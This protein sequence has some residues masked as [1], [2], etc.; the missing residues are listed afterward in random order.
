MPSRWEIVHAGLTRSIGS[1]R[2]ARLFQEL[3]QVPDTPLARFVVAAALITWVD[4]RGGDTVAL[5]ETDR[6]LA[7]LVAAAG[8][9]RTTTLAVEL[10]L[11][12]LWPGLSAVF[13]RLSRLYRQRPDDLAIEILD[14]FTI[15]V[16][17]LDLT[18]CSR[19]A[20]TLVRNTERVVSAAR[21]SELKAASRGQSP[22]SACD[23]LAD[24]AAEHAAALVDL[25]VWLRDVVPR[26]AELV[27]G[28]FVGGQ[29]CREAGARLGISHA[30]ARQRLARAR[31]RMRPLLR[32]PAHSAGHTRPRGWS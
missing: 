22:D 32:T 28:V 12:L 29:N 9:P 25:R 5:D 19:V 2:S 23:A 11:L 31:A 14:R 1:E 8:A 30:S 6:I 7:A 18:G 10:L 3:R 17:R 21:V 24:H 15:C 27:M 26:D 4:D 20:A 16:R 13:M